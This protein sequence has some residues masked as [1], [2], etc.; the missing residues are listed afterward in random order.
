MRILPILLVS[1]IAYSDTAHGKLSGQAKID[2]LLGQLAKASSDT[3]R[4]N[5]LNSASFSYGVVDPDKGIALARQSLQLNSELQWPKGLAN[6]YNSLYTNY[7]N[8]AAN[9]SALYY[10]ER[11]MKINEEIG[12]A[13]GVAVNLGNIA[14]IYESQSNFAKALDYQF[15]SLKQREEIADKGLLATCLMNIGNIYM[16]IGD[17]AKQ[18]EYHAAALKLA[19]EMHDK[20]LLTQCYVNLGNG[21]YTQKDMKNA[22]YYFE[23]ALKAA[24]EMGVRLQEQKVIGNIG[25]VQQA[26]GNHPLALQYAF[27]SLKMCEETGDIEGVA[28]EIADIGNSYLALAMGRNNGPLPDS[29]A[30]QSKNNFLKKAINYLGLGSAKAKEMNN[31]ML[32]YQVLYSLSE[33]YE[34]LGDHS[35]ALRAHREYA[36]LKDSV[37]SIDNKIKFANLE[38]ERQ[39]DLKEKQIELNRLTQK[40]RDRQQLFLL[41]GIALLA[42]VTVVV[43]RAN[44]KQKR[45]NLQLAQ[46][47]ETSEQLRHNLEL[48]LEQKNVL[49]DEI[50]AAAEMKSKFLANISHELRTPVTLL[51]GMLELARNE[52]TANNKEKLTI[53][54]NN[55]VRLQHMVDELLDLSKLE[56]PEATFDQAQYEA[57]PLIAKIADG[58]RLLAERAQLLFRFEN[59][60]L[61]HQYFTMDPEALEKIISNLIYNAIKFTQPGGSIRI[62]TSLGS[63]DVIQISIADTGTGISEKDL[64]HIFE[65]F[66]Q[67][68]TAEAKAK[69]AGI[70]LSLVKEYTAALGGQVSVTSEQGKGTTF[71]LSFPATDLKIPDDTLHGDWEEVQL[72]RNW[73]QF[74]GTPVVLI[75]EDNAEMRFYLR[76][77]LKE[78]VTVEEAPNGKAALEWLADHDA[79]LIITDMMMPE[80]DG[81]SFITAIKAS[82]KLRYTPIITVSALAGQENQL[83]VLRLGVDDYIIKPFNPLE[84][85]VRVFN[86]LNN[87]QERK[88]FIAGQEE[89]VEDIQED[90]AHAEEFRKRINDFVLSHAKNFNITVYDIAYEMSMSERQL[91][92]LTKSL[93]GCTPAQLIKEIRLQKAHE[94]LLSGTI[95]KVESVARA[96]GFDN[97]SYFSRQ[98]FERFGRKPSD[99]LH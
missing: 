51:T 41:G 47:K 7:F 67:G 90:S 37:F 68:A 53:A 27:R 5:I 85:Q 24:E 88:Q 39:A 20:E 64:P 36:K 25:S 74:D 8:R 29:L 69:G 71:T 4:I 30:A 94:L 61:G 84:L 65:R 17:L 12:N 13:R 82:E 6:A 50:A 43:I 97:V 92:R 73:E 63:N 34:A 56:R 75:V 72:T 35:A 23:L 58:Y 1:L 59:N 93:T 96:V 86:L 45:A 60:G 87:R 78:K 79:D 31:L 70:G 54:Y 28:Y 76:T 62:V 83:S 48:T 40:Q 55:G 38:T 99:Y 33:A 9:D 44:N 19:L 26:M 16:E 18:M 49:V 52:A 14:N 32:N 42:T 66:Y 15:R 46:E 95:H 11:S 21:Y 2:S 89:P 10:A 98:F 3:A 81:R 22:L 77:I 57:L 91:Y 80:M